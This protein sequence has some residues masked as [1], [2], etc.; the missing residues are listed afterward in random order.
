MLEPT[1]LI[2][3][4]VPDPN[5]PEYTFLHQVKDLCQKNSTLFILEEMITGFRWHLQCDQ[6]Q[7]KIEPDFCAFG[8]AIAN[9]FAVFALYGYK[10]FM[11]IS[12]IQTEGAKRVFFHQQYMV[13]KW[14]H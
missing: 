10:E 2:D 1:A 13:P 3:P 6:T 4:R 9:G 5:R 8:K 12:G 7:Y 11:Q 14:V